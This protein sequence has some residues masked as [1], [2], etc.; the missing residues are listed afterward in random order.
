MKAKINLLVTSLIGFCCLISCEDEKANNSMTQG[1]S[2]IDECFLVKGENGKLLDL[3][4]TKDENNKM[5]ISAKPSDI[6]T[7]IDDLP[8]FIIVA[9]DV[10]YNEH[11]FILPKSETAYWVFEATLGDLNLPKA[12]DGETISA[13]CNCLSYTGGCVTSITKRANNVFYAN[14]NSSISSPCSQGG[15]G[16]DLCQWTLPEVVIKDKLFSETATT[17]IVKSDIIEYNGLIFE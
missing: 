11:S 12:A 14:C 3:Q 7:N 10:D 5:I 4:I 8:D 6:K 9:D 15:S 2:F 17:L 16:S 13:E 1:E